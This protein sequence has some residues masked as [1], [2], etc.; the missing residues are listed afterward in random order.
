MPPARR[1]PFLAVGRQCRVSKNRP[2]AV[3]IWSAG[4]R[5]AVITAH[6]PSK[7][8]VMCDAHPSP[9]G[10]SSRSSDPAVPY[11]E[12]LPLVQV[13]GG[14]VCVTVRPP[15]GAT[16]GRLAEQLRPWFPSPNG[17]LPC[18]LLRGQVICAPPTRMHSVVGVLP[19]PTELNRKLAEYRLSS[20]EVITVRPAD[21]GRLVAIMLRLEW[22][23][24]LGL[25]ATARAQRVSAGRMAGKFMAL[26]RDAWDRLLDQTINV[27][28]CGAELT[29]ALKKTLAAGNAQLYR[30]AAAAVASCTAV[31]RAAGWRDSLRRHWAH[32]TAESD[33]VGVPAPYP[34]Q[35]LMVH[36]YRMA[37]VVVNVTHFNAELPV[38]CRAARVL[39][40]LIAQ[41]LFGP[42]VVAL[43]GSSRCPMDRSVVDAAAGAFYAAACSLKELAGRRS[44]ARTYVAVVNALCRSF[45]SLQPVRVTADGQIELERG[46]AAPD[47]MHSDWVQLIRGRAARVQ[48]LVVDT[49]ASSSRPATAVH[50]MLYYYRVFVEKTEGRARQLINMA[51]E[52][53]TAA[54]GVSSNSMVQT[55][56]P[57]PR[58]NWV[59]RLISGVAA[60]AGIHPTVAPGVVDLFTT[61]SR[62]L[63]A[64]IVVHPEMEDGRSTLLRTAADVLGRA[65]PMAQISAATARR[66]WID[67]PFGATMSPGMAVLTGVQLMAQTMP[68][69]GWPV[70]L[71][72]VGTNV[73]LPV[74]G[75][76]WRPALCTGVGCTRALVF[77]S[78]LYRAHFRGVYGAFAR[79]LPQANGGRTVLPVELVG[80]IL[81]AVGPEIMPP[82]VA[83]SIVALPAMPSE[84]S[85]VRLWEADEVI[86][87][88]FSRDSRR[89]PEAWEALYAQVAQHTGSAV[90]TMYSTPQ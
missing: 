74:P 68:S 5:L 45:G 40:L 83:R 56:L 16:V 25:Q 71:T 27:H 6:L 20:G 61:L 82:R 55:N 60:G 3:V 73:M 63:Q 34:A 38:R 28:E 86:C 53:R 39:T 8:L 15:V 48:T 12:M 84:W 47:S 24:R 31:M 18:L 22:D 62:Q 64:T 66:L 67:R 59:G 81:K 77:R 80:L 79:G 72:T 90:E 46:S 4:R 14:G 17:E 49:V 57:L 44:G 7:L 10:A 23:V 32:Q 35:L 70:V 76:A 13:W 41:T 50:E 87:S 9:V 26:V 89:S 1:G 36:M 54:T 21:I 29:A 52:L 75:A 2:G 85:R 19:Y 43:H 88:R 11:R 65:G 58:G 37:L 30:S 69:L 51:V 33:P 42:P 78:Q